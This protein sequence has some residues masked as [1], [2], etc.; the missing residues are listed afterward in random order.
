MSRSCARPSLRPTWLLRARYTDELRIEPIGTAQGL[1]QKRT[2]LRPSGDGLRRASEDNEVPHFRQDHPT[3]PSGLR[4]ID[5]STGSGTASAN[6]EEP[7]NI[8][9]PTFAPR[10]HPPVADNT[11]RPSRPRPRTLA[12]RTLWV[13]TGIQDSCMAGDDGLC[14]RVSLRMFGSQFNGLSYSEA[15]GHTKI[16]VEGT[17]TQAD[18]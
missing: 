14:R 17:S 9:H 2:L 15:C 4:R 3:S 10:A 12:G 5:P 7:P 1:R 8:Q 13:V 6:C 16:S 18:A 11:Q